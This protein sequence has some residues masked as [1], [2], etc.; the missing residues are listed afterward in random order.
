MKDR[1]LSRLK[2]KLKKVTSTHDKIPMKSWRLNEQIKDYWSHFNPNQGMPMDFV[3]E[4]REE[5]K[6]LRD[7]TLEEQ[8]SEFDKLSALTPDNKPLPN[9]FSGLKRPTPTKYD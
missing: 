4:Q 5:F 1:K 9:P 3:E 6:K 8:K 2:R 7:L